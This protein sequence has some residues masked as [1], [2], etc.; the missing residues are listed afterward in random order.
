MID[1]TLNGNVMMIITTI[2]IVQHNRIIIIICK[3]YFINTIKNNEQI[4]Y[5]KYCK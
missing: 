2:Y 1:D 5:N 4:K 3:A